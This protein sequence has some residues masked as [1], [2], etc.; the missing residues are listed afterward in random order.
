MITR[1][2]M[3]PRRDGLRTEQFL[4]HWR[5][6]HAEAAGQIPHVRRYVQLHPV[7]VDGRLPLPHP[8]FDACSMM[9]FDDLEAMDDAFTS[10]PY[11]GDVRDDEDRFIRNDRHSRVVTRRQVVEPLPDHEGV[12]I[13]TY[14]RRHP[15]AT[16]EDFRSRVV[17]A[18]TTPHGAPGREQA[19][20]IDAPGVSNAVDA[21]DLRGFGS[22]AEALAW[23]TDEDGGVAATLQLAGVVSGVTHV[24]V[25]PHRVL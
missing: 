15:D 22:S 24:V 17:D 18:A 11:R 6:A 12:A 9:D 10:A 3:A 16:A 20:A 19:L 4:D 14:L 8:G 7:L 5:T 23:L 2:G 1:F 25:R 13:A 21:I